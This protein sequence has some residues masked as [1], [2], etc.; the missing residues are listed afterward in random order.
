MAKNAYTFAKR[1]KELAKKQKKEEKKQRRSDRVEAPEGPYY[2]EA[3]G[4]IVY[5]ESKPEAEPDT[6]DEAAPA[7]DQAAPSPDEKTG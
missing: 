6:G 3:T 5:P 1:S 4:Q 2:D 7:G